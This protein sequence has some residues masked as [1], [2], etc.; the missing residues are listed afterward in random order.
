MVGTSRLLSKAAQLIRTNE[1]LNAQLV[2]QRIEEN[3]NEDKPK[4]LLPFRFPN[5]SIAKPVSHPEFEFNSMK[6]LLYFQ[7][8]IRLSSL[9][10]DRCIC[11][12]KGPLVVEKC[13]LLRPIQSLELG[14]M[15]PIL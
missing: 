4:H 12:I 5:E 14:R 9:L 1:D 13:D 10:G 15:R 6:T 3:K 8:L 2:I 7:F 11:P